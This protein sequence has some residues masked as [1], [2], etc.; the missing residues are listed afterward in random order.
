MKP[1][2]L[3]GFILIEFPSSNDGW[4]NIGVM[5]CEQNENVPK[6]K[7]TLIWGI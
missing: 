3:Q 5:E 7:A 1:H 6:R 2:S 4:V